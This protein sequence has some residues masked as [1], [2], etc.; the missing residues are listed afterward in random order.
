MVSSRIVV[1]A[2][3]SAAVLGCASPALAG[4]APTGPLVYPSLVNERLVRVQ[5]ALDRAAVSADEHQPS[6]AAATLMSARVNLRKAW[7]SAKYVIQNT[8]APPPVVDDFSPAFHANAFTRE[9]RLKLR[10]LPAA[11]R[12]KS[13]AKAHSKRV[14]RAQD[15]VPTGPAATIYDTAFAVLSLQ[16]RMA[17]LSTGLI[18][19]AHSTL[20][21][22]LST[23][24]FTALNGRDQAITYI[25]SIDV[26]PPP[27]V[28]DRPIAHAADDPAPV[29]WAVVMPNVSP[30]IDD[31][32]MQVNGT[33][34]SG[35]P[36][37]AGTQRVLQA[38]LTQDTAT[39][40]AVDAAWPALP[41][42]ED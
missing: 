13:K 34:N 18:D 24:L 22:S 42:A 36:L 28:D 7:I 40:A 8:P 32:V 37:R 12:T 38:A 29:G 4:D 17:T 15:L 19:T 31:E 14:R 9:G 1:A 2:A 27:P 16:H 20:Q 5:A 21:S 10:T 6:A 35:T 26:A 39:K 33:M 41:P 3:T 11:N 30:L 23:S 25:K